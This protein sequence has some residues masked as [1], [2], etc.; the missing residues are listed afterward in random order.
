MKKNKLY[1]IFVAVIF[2][3][4]TISGYNIGRAQSIDSLMIPAKMDSNTILIYDNELN[5]HVINNKENRN[6]FGYS[7]NVLSNI[8]EDTSGLDE[9]EQMIKKIREEAKNLP[10]FDVSEDYIPTANTMV[11]YG[12]DGLINRIVEITEETI[13][14][15]IPEEKI[16]SIRDIISLDTNNVSLYSITPYYSS[17]PRG[18]RKPAGVYT[19][20]GGSKLTIT[21]S[22]VLGEGRLSTFGELESDSIGE[23]G[24]N[25]PNR[26]G[27]CAT[28]GDYD[29]APYHQSIRVR[30]LDNNIV[31]NL[32]KNDNGSLPYAVLDIYKWSG[33]FLGETWYNGFTFE[34]GR[35][36]YE[37]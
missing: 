32:R 17:L 37:F 14:A 4:L 24:R 30:N 22:Y 28:K 6:T 13:Q 34:N 35:Y 33:K 1:K 7:E 2:S 8:K 10:H 21:N 19:W 20:G 23:N 11:I 29:N 27:D 3:V 9:E 18:T 5:M 26:Q 31:H 25:D 12:S 36:Y 16:S 15:Y